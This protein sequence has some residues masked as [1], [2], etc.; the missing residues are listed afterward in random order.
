[1]DAIQSLTGCTYGKGNLFHVD[2]GKNAFTFIRRS[3]GKAIR[4][5][6]RADAWGAP[7]PEH[8][9]LRAK[10]FGGQATDEEHALF[11]EQHLARADAILARP[12]EQMFT[13]TPVQPQMPAKA[14]VHQSVICTSCGESVMETRSRL[15]RGAT[16]CIPCFEQRDR[17]YTP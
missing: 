5:V 15:F 6:T 1:M 11:Q 10:V 16:Y 3:D 13:V 14:R 9:A 7:D 4:I 2:Y 12:L 17:R 8:Q